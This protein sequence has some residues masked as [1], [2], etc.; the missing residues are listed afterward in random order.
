MVMLLTGRF[1]N[2]W[3]NG[4]LFRKDTETLMCDPA[5]VGD[6][7]VLVCYK[8]MM[9]LASKYLLRYVPCC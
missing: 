8:Y 4:S 6:L 3:D 5:G 7:C 2:A 9:P 1:L